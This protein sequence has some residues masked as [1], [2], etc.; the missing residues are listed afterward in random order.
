MYTRK[1]QSA[2]K[3]RLKSPEPPPTPIPTPPNPKGDRKKLL[4]DSP[5]LCNEE[6][7]W[8]GLKDETLLTTTQSAHRVPATG[9][10]RVQAGANAPATAE[11]ASAHATAG[12]CGERVGGE[13]QQGEPERQ[14]QRGRAQLC[15]QRAQG[16]WK[17]GKAGLRRGG[18]RGAKR[19][20]LGPVT[21]AARRNAQRRTQR[22]R[23]APH[24]LQSE[25][26]RG[27]AQRGERRSSRLTSRGCTHPARGADRADSTRL[28]AARGGRFSERSSNVEPRSRERA[29]GRT[30]AQEKG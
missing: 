1:A 12:A 14:R 27:S 16:G 9:C 3:A 7:L 20:A 26:L 19:C 5:K 25:R 8:E 4:R 15:Q 18:K 10:H 2:R 13:R 29:V 17:E 22:P 23:R 28:H 11:G 30:K 21:A 24:R 6:E